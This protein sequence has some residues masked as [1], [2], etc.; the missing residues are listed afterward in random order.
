[1]IDQR[2]KDTILERAQI[3]DVVSDFVSLRRS[4]VSYIGLCP[5]H[6]DRRPSFSVSPAKN[7]CKCFSCGEGGSPVHFIMKHEQLS[8]T[9]ALRYLAKKYHIEIVERELTNEERQQE[10]ERQSLFLVNEFALKF[11]HENLRSGSSESAIAQAYFQERGI[12]PETIERFSLGYAPELRTA[13]SEQAISKGYSA[14]RLLK[15]GLASQ[16]EPEGQLVDRF[17]GRIIFPVLNLGG[18]CVAFGGRIMGK[19]DK[20]AKYI[21]SP[22]SSIYS[23]SRELYGLYWARNAIAKA[24]KC[25]LVEGYTDVI[26]MYQSGI[27]NVVASSGTALTQQQIRLIR[28]FTEHITVLYDG[29]WAGIKA[30][31][32]GIDLLLEE[33][34]QIKV[35][36]LPE[37]EDPDSFARSHNASELNA[38]LNESEVDFIQFKINLY[39]EDM[40]RDPLKRAELIS[41]ILRSIALIPEEIRRAVYVQTTAKELRMS[42]QLLNREVFKLRQRGLSASTTHIG[43]PTPQRSETILP[44]VQKPSEMVAT[45]DHTEHSPEP[46][47]PQTQQVERYE[48]ELLK[49]LIAQGSKTVL[50]EIIQEEAEPPVWLETSLANFVHAELVYSNLLCALSQTAQQI[51]NEANGLPLESDSSAYFINHQSELIRRISTDLLSNPYAIYEQAETA[52]EQGEENSQEQLTKRHKRLGLEVL[53]ELDNIRMQMIMQDIRALQSE[54]ITLQRD[55][56]QNDAR[57]MEI[58]VEINELNQIKRDIAQVLGERTIIA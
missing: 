32:R 39:Q 50:V 10:S 47:L 1:M 57:I 25:Y 24:D 23:K 44:T 2:T 54:M 17:R 48:L 20:L 46:T 27:E 51:V 4:G 15:V 30:A 11:F 56:Q 36:L 58:M 12:R 31:L 34:L 14:D 13:L 55:P 21:N 49:M 37:G 16:Y 6:S 40:K 53:R 5:F 43:T 18:K 19:S 45:F 42:E 22:E 33:G 35:V 8:Y 9:E 26:S 52:Q 3:L 7:V 29:D 28:R 41:D 38:F